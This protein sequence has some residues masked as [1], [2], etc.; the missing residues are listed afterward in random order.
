MGGGYHGLLVQVAVACALSLVV[1]LGALAWSAA[2]ATPDGSILA[3]R[4]NDR[5]PRF[6]ALVA[7]TALWFGIAEA[8]EPHHAAAAPLVILLAL[9]AVTW[10]VRQIALFAVALVAHVVFAIAR[11][12]FSPRS[13]SWTRRPRTS[14]P[15]RRIVAGRRRFARPP[16]I[17]SLHR[18]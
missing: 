16:P 7:A 10:I 17:V 1:G 4:L 3:V 18:A 13:P 5:L 11:L 2:G 9:F 6:G 12:A 8:I 14:A 15:R